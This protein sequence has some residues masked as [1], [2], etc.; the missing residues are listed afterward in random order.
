MPDAHD[1]PLDPERLKDFAKHV[2]GALGGAMTSAMI[3]LGDR[4]GLYRALA[5]GGPADERR[6]SRGAPGSP[7]AGCASG[8][9]SKAR[10]ACSS[11]SATALRALARGPR[12]ARRRAHPAFGGGMFSPLPDTIAVLERLPEAF[13]SGIGLPYD[14]FGPGGARGVERGFAPWYRALL[15]PMALPRIAGVVR[16][17]ERGAR[18]ADVGCGAGVALLEMAKAFPKS[19]FHGYD[20]SHH[21]LA[22][23][24]ANR[25]PRAPQRRTSTTRAA[26]R[27]PTTRA[28]TS[29]PP[30]T[31]CTT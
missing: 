21:A 18:V 17:L 11:T 14:A 31:A 7:S 19:E 27:C 9:T 3:C 15:V 20:I 13:A 30:S 26:S 16:A 6:S 23:A 29:S 1:R 4:L 2:F 24:E 8:C 5:N 10:R 25:A 12:R 28:S 22:R